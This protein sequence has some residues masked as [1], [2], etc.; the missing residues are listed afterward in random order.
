MSFIESYLKSV[1]SVILFLPLLAVG[2]EDPDGAVPFSTNVCREVLN[3]DVESPF[4]VIKKM[5]DYL[6]SIHT[7]G[8]QQNQNNLLSIAETLSLSGRKAFV[9][10]A[11]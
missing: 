1:L 9:L 8:F 3:N 10:V 5:I 2:H 6:Q 11:I 7:Q 4:L